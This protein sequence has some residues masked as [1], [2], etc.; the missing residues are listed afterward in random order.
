M[1]LVNTTRA[2]LS[3]AGLGIAAALAFAAPASAAP[4][5][6]TNL[7]NPAD[8]NL[9]VVGE[10]HSYLHNFGFTFPAGSITAVSL[11]VS[12]TDAGGSETFNFT[13][14]DA[15]PVSSFQE[16]NISSSETVTDAWIAAEFAAIQ[17]GIIGVTITL[18]STNT[19]SP[20]AVFTQSLLSV[21]YDPQTTTTAVPE[22][23]SFALLGGALLAA[24]MIRRRKA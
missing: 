20:G 17:D 16:I 6:V 10:Q 9:D 4:V 19:S 8:I 18:A 15:V 5:T 12:F 21:T 22:P 11:E 13:Y 23:G 3:L 24:G 1:S 7:Y 2:H 14:T